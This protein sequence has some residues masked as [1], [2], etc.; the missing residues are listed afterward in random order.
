MR[1]GMNASSG[2][3]RRTPTGTRRCRPRRAAPPSPAMPRPA[4]RHPAR[5]RCVSP[6]R[7]H[8]AQS[9]AAF[10]VR[11]VE[12]DPS[13]PRLELA[14]T[15]LSWLLP[16][17]E[18]APPAEGAEGG[19]EG[20]AAPAEGAE[21]AEGADGA[22]LGDTTAKRRLEVLKPTLDPKYA[23]PLPHAEQNLRTYL[24]FHNPRGFDHSAAARYPLPPPAPPAA[25]EGEGEGGDG[26]AGEE[27]GASD[28]PEP[29]LARLALM[30][31]VPADGGAP[32]PPLQH[33]QSVPSLS[34][35]AVRLTS[36]DFASSTGALPRT[37]TLA[38]APP[39]RPQVSF[40][41][42]ADVLLCFASAAAC[43]ALRIETVDLPAL[44]GAAPS[45]PPAP[46]GG[47]ADQAG[48][49]AA[50]AVEA[51]TSSSRAL[52]L[53]LPPGRTLLRL[54]LPREFSSHV[55]A[56]A[57]CP[58]TLAPE[59]DALR[60]AGLAVASLA[61][62]A[63]APLPAGADAV[64]FRA[65]VSV[66]A[67]GPATFSLALSHA[68]LAPL[69]QL[70]LVDGRTGATLAAPHDSLGPVHLEPQPEGYFLAARSYHGA[71]PGGGAA[72]EGE[73]SADPLGGTRWEVTAVSPAA[74]A[75]AL[76]ALPAEHRFAANGY[77]VRNFSRELF[78]YR[79]APPAEG[80][81]VLSALL[82]A[83]SPAE[84]E[85]VPPPLPTVAP[86]RVPT[87][88]SL[89][90]S[91]VLI[92]APAD[93]VWTPDLVD[94][95][96]GAPPLVAPA[97]PADPAAEGGTSEPA[98]AEGAEEGAEAGGAAPAAAAEARPAAIERDGE[99]TGAA[100]RRAAGL[101]ACMIAETRVLPPPLP[102]TNRTSLVPP[103][104]LSGHA[105]SLRS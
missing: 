44:R 55:T 84:I 61:G 99:L 14:L 43:G 33:T 34:A 29:P 18:P 88:H 95:A 58:F 15:R 51:A 11:L 19:A 63:P 73:Q 53:R 31:D 36:A 7:D 102:R 62:V 72:S 78:R 59:P 101:N 60:A 4:P 93:A 79:V 35:G 48:A 67:P 77:F 24:L 96:T 82:R 76:E 57:H 105:A 104:V 54:E 6:A 45:G 8:C 47:G 17:A 92:E 49:P 69:V 74:A 26:A 20:G 86:T 71:P 65:R 85:L 32:A 16:R 3:W 98:P 37:Q 42:G 64:W 81:L 90:S 41:D 50:A 23:C 68:P 10:A 21:G 46:I 80:G 70:L 100:L 97:S 9:D 22:G 12:S 83:H 38:G 94:P 27:E 2:A 40:I 89:P 13:D 87:V 52:L 39:L 28:A 30:V 103:L 25:Q 5:P 66:P 75:V 56:A 91:Q 1:K